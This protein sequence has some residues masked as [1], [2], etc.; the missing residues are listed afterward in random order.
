[1]DFESDDNADNVN[2]VDNADNNTSTST[3]VPIIKIAKNELPGPETFSVQLLQFI[4]K[5]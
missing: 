3:Y 4:K 1:M 5:V 2:T